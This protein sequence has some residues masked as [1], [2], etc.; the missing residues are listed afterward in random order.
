MKIKVNDNYPNDFLTIQTGHIFHR[1]GNSQDKPMSVH[2]LDKD[3]FEMNC[4]FND[5]V[6][7][8]VEDEPKEIKEEKIKMDK[9]KTLKSN[10]LK[11]NTTIKEV[12]SSNEDKD[13]ESFDFNN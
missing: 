4:L 10:S 1:K 6:L 7:V 11:E 13:S 2:E 3:N 12:V 5:K 8:P 9:P